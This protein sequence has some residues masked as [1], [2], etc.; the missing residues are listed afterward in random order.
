M[1]R[2]AQSQDH[3]STIYGTSKLDL[4]ISLRS[5]STHSIVKDKVTEQYTEIDY[6][7]TLNDRRRCFPEEQGLSNILR[8]SIFSTTNPNIHIK[9]KEKESLCDH[10]HNCSKQNNDDKITQKSIFKRENAL[11][12]AVVAHTE[13][14]SNLQK[15][16]NNNPNMAD[17]STNPQED[18][19]VHNILQHQPLQHA[20]LEEESSTRLSFSIS[21]SIYTIKDNFSNQTI[22]HVTTQPP[23]TNQTFILS[24]PHPPITS[25]VP[26]LQP[27]PSTRRI[28][29]LSR[30]PS[31]TTLIVP[32]LHSTPQTCRT[33][34]HSTYTGE[35]VQLRRFIV[36]ADSPV[37]AIHYYPTYLAPAIFAHEPLKPQ[38]KLRP[39]KTKFCTKIKIFLI[40]KFGLITFLWSRNAGK[41][42]KPDLLPVYILFL[43][44]ERS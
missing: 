18:L 7:P 9:N 5:Y 13:Q 10:E 30:E 35:Q 37:S 3:S 33:Q 21:N 39:Q 4:N 41:M 27:P 1:P 14:I 24:L 15:L 25:F 32:L 16:N 12:E 19:P 40:I 26:T 34:N 20:E 2:V 36:P 43:K 44:S 23:P 42:F 11:V 6:T 29:F 31:P 22:S 38:H 8:H 17:D 28:F